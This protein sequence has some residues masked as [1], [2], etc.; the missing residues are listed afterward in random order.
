LFH[1]VLKFNP[2]LIVLTNYPNDDENSLPSQTYFSLLTTHSQLSVD[3][4]DKWT[5]SEI[6]S[7]LE[8][9]NKIVENKA[10]VITAGL[11]GSY[12][13]EQVCAVFDYLFNNWNYKRDPD[14]KEYFR[15]ASL[16]VT[17]LTG[18]CEDYAIAMVSLLKALGGD[19]RIICVSGHAYPEVYI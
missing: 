9:D 5:A 6:S 10:N 1:I 7:A 16:T 11:K 3:W 19:G 15:E 17:T 18:D 12:S 13:I 2:K 8:P 4:A 14:G